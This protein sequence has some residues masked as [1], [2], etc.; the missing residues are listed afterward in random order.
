ML[1]GIAAHPH[2]APSEGNLDARGKNLVVAFLVL[3]SLVF[4]GAGLI[5]LLRMLPQS[6]S[7]DF[8]SIVL[9]LTAFCCSFAAIRG[10]VVIPSFVHVHET[11]DS[12]ELAMADV[13]LHHEA[14]LVNAFAR[15]MFFAWATSLLFLSISAF[16][17]GLLGKL[18]PICGIVLA[19]VLLLLLF[20]GGVGMNLH[21][22]GIIVLASSIWLIAIGIILCRAVV[23]DGENN[24]G[25]VS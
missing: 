19:V 24:P 13:V 11:Q 18:T 7:R 15:T 9:V 10:H 3:T 23:R 12:T 6:L 2:H 4:T 16:R 8:A 21:D 1:A 14:A 20:A 5:R 17:G 22:V 25:E